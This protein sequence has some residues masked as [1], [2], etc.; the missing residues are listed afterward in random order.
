MV[1]KSEWEMP[2]A[3]WITATSVGLV[4]QEMPDKEAGRVERND[5]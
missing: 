4:G 2:L 5:W 3:D 1:G